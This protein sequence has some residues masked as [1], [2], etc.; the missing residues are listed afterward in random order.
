[1]PSFNDMQHAF[2]SLISTIEL[3]DIVDVAVLAYIVYLLLKLIREK[4]PSL[5]KY[6]A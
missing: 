6:H 1:M 4:A 2:F 5:L 3:K